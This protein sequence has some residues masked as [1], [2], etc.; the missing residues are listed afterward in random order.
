MECL[1]LE[2]SFEMSLNHGKQSAIDFAGR[3]VAFLADAVASVRQASKER[4]QASNEIG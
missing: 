4:K 2:R 3:F 1:T